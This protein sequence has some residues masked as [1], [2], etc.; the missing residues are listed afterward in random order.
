MID[1]QLPNSTGS[2]YVNLGCNPWDPKD[3][4]NSTPSGSLLI[5]AFNYY[6]VLDDVNSKT[7]LR[8]IRTQAQKWIF[9]VEAEID[10]LEA[11]KMQEFLAFYPLI[12]HIAFSKPHPQEK[13]DTWMQSALL[14]MAGGQKADK[15]FFMSWVL[16]TLIND[17]TKIPDNIYR[18][19][20]S[21]LRHWNEDLEYNRTTFR[22][23]APGDSLRV[24]SFLFDELLS[25]PIYKPGKKEQLLEKGL[26]LLDQINNNPE[27]QYT[28]LID[29]VNF[30]QTFTLSFPDI[31]CDEIRQN[32]LLR[33]ST[34]PKLSPQSRL[35]FSL[36]LLSSD[37]PA[38]FSAQ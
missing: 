26:Q 25:Y 22:G 27:A 14:K 15:V 23:M 7:F 29:A 3:L 8:D 21:V 6:S 2:A 35:A 38:I 24:I 34:S 33:L 28:E 11:G 18:W 36:Y 9:E 31:D 17:H 4:N 5:A 13:Y 37:P 1:S 32:L 16:H 10:T 12:H 19:Y 20:T 30:C